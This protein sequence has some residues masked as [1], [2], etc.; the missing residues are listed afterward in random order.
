MRDFLY[1]HLIV[2]L[3]RCDNFVVCYTRSGLHNGILATLLIGQP[4]VKSTVSSTLTRAQVILRTKGSQCHGRQ[5]CKGLQLMDR[6]CNIATS[7]VSKGRTG[8]GY[9]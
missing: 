3:L 1:W 8:T 7:Q 2:D 4:H 5:G 6:V 9:L